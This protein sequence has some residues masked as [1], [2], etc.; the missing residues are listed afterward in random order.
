M[1]HPGG[2]PAGSIDDAIARM[3]RIIARCAET[4]DARGWFAVVYR[5]VT[6]RVR[7]GIAVGAF[8]DGE[9][10]EAFDVRFANHWLDA[11]EAWDR[12]TPVSASWACSFEAAARPGVILQHLLLGMNAHINLDLGLAAAQTCPGP[13]VVELRDDFERI[14]DVL[15]ELVDAM[16]AAIS[17]VSPMTRVLDVVG[18]R[19]DEAMVSFSLAQARARSWRFAEELAGAGLAP[20]LVDARDVAVAG[21]GA[22]LARPG[23][24]MR[25]VLP[26]ARWRE[27]PDLARVAGLLRARGADVEI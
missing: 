8:D 22:R 15:A 18:L 4:R 19:L 13:E 26:I 27:E 21:Y 6:A 23:F 9:R 14:N 25:C 24:A 12:A 5:A 7:D 10:M 2:L 11:Y 1:P 20:A 16:Q 3:D 17:E